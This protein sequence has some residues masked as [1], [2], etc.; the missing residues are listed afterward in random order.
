MEQSIGLSWPLLNLGGLTVTVVLFL[1]TVEVWL[2][3]RTSKMFF[4][5]ETTIKE[6]VV[7][8]HNPEDNSWFSFK[9]ISEEKNLVT[10]LKIKLICHD[11]D[12]LII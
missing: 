8:I 3:L 2:F 11:S 1:V 6:R 10:V 9:E 4:H 5:S 12:L 7:M